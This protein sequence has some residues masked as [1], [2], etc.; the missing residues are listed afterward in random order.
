MELGYTNVKNYKEG[1]LTWKQELNPVKVSDYE[2]NLRLYPATNN[3]D[4]LTT[5]NRARMFDLKRCTHI[6][7]Q[8]AGVVI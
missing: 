6:N 7:Q 1:F 8:H 4:I 5:L 2:P 3:I